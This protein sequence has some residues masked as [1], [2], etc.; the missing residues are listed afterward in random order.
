MST[1]NGRIYMNDDM[2]ES[3]ANYNEAANSF[4]DGIALENIM[5]DTDIQMEFDLGDHD[6]FSDHAMEAIGETV[7]NMA[8]KAKSNFVTY[9]KK[10]INFLFGWLIRFFQGAAN[11]KK[12]M[13]KAYDKAKVYLKKLNELET[14]ARSANKEDKI[15]I[16]DYGNCVLMGLTMI[17]LIIM[18]SYNLGNHLKTVMG[19]HSDKSGTQQRAID[20]V[21]SLCTSLETMYSV[22]AIIDIK[23]PEELLSKVRSKN[24]NFAAVYEEYQ[25]DTS[26]REKVIQS[27]RKE[28]V[29]NN[30]EKTGKFAGVVTT[31]QEQNDNYESKN[32]TGTVNSL[33]KKYL[34]RLTEAAEYMSDP[35]TAE[36]SIS[37]AFDELRT[38]L[39]LFMDISKNNKWDL[40]KN[41]Q[42][43][44]KI[45]RGLEKELNNVDLTTVN[46]K[47]MTDLLKEVVSVGN[48]LGQ[49]S[50]G[51]G[52]VMSKL[53]S[54]IDGMTTDVAKLGSR[55]IKI[56]DKA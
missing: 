53:S 26:K 30:D 36:L 15:E 45:R 21:K 34:S 6:V 38:K 31:D 1:T 23:K 35:R 39:K 42:G 13:A 9:A 29:K 24:F 14:K 43:A 27:S 48:N 54:C 25:N 32:S 40:E 44:E 33:E 16:R 19:A 47:I 22:V 55:V 4:L 28:A 46:E 50:K 10:L 18:S 12:T 41:I 37:D 56:G 20:M 52:Q 7:K 17:Q 3:Y 8:S 11:V 2:L 49:M 51:A 5:L